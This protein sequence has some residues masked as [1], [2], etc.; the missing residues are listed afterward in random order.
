MRAPPGATKRIPLRLRD[1]RL[2]P[3]PLPAHLL[4]AMSLWLSSRAALPSLKYVLPPSSAGRRLR[5]LAQEIDAFGVEAVGRA[6]DAEIARR[7]ERCL[8][9][10]ERY[11]KHP[12][13]RPPPDARP[14]WQEDASR[15]LDFGLHPG[16]PGVLIVP[17]LVNRY[18][19]LDLL[20]Q[21]SFVRHLA[22]SGLRPL[23][24]DWGTPGVEERR[25]D[26]TD[27][28]AGRLDAAF[29]AAREIA[30]APLAVIGYCMGGLMALALALHR[31]NETAAL[32]LL[33][34][35]WDFHAVNEAQARLLGFLA[36]S[37]PLVSP[38]GLAPVDVIQTLFFLL[39]PFAAERKF[40]RFGSYDPDSEEARLFVAL[41]DWIN[42][43]APLPLPVMQDC[44][45]GWYGEN[46]P[47]RGLWRVA[48][49]RVEP[50]LLRLPSLVV[51]PRAD[52]IVPPRSAAPLAE[53]LGGEVL[54]PPLGHIGM[55][56]AAR[57]PELLWDPIAHW[58]RRHFSQ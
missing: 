14:L 26:L 24:V 44:L 17:S 4:G 29:S 5:A 54:R 21:R 1:R 34:T 38:E 39:D 45:R 32:V 55:M 50:Q 47:A 22:Q 6:L 23:V 37:L 13:R 19:V 42:G 52:R 48:D 16:A 43:G 11:R 57:A 8:E 36:D 46:E 40:A 28:I 31:R 56:S 27:Y 12:Y 25:F 2:L 30:G 7:A 20:P 33:A 35:P 49:R 9:G 41:E 58:L 15:L 18:D 10:L 3:R 53:A 51:V